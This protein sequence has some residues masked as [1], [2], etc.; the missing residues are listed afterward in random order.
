MAI[1]WRALGLE[2]VEDLLE[3]LLGFD[4]G[5]DGL[6]FAVGGDDE[7]GAFG[8]EVGFAVHGFFDPDAVGFGDGVVFVDDE[9]K[10]EVELFDEFLVAGGGVDADAADFGFGGNG[11]PVIAEGAGLFGAAGGVVFGVE[12][13]DDGVA[14]EAFEIE[15]GVGSDV[16]A[17]DRGF[18]GGGGFADGGVGGGAH[19]EERNDGMRAIGCAKVA[20]RWGRPAAWVGR[21]GRVCQR[22]SMQSP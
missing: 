18:E 2:G 20:L 7:G 19:V 15:E 12:V 1:L 22:I 4:L 21:R 6:E 3:V 8:A 10:G 16:G 13:E 14:F 11:G 9:G 17:D 5:E